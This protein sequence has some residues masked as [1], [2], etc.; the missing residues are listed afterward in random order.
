MTNPKPP[1]AKPEA[2]TEAAPVSQDV[3]LVHRVTPDGSVH[4]IRRRGDTIEAGA[5]RP[6]V[7]GAPVH[8][9]VVA[10]RPREDLPLLCDV[11]VLYAPP[12]TAKASEPPAAPR[13][14][15]RKGPAQVATDVYRDNW[16]SIW[17]SKK[18]DALN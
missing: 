14:G 9:E 11:D 1:R 17:S 10:L 15:R 8:G 16:D 3:A 6:L 12:T 4:V 7:E 13:P 18:S 2:S 5:L